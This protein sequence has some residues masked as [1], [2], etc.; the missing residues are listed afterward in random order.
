MK[1]A[2]Y[3]ASHSIDEWRRAYIDYRQLK[4]QIGRAEEELFEI[5]EGNQPSGGIGL[6]PRKKSKDRV[7]KRPSSG[8]EETEAVRDLERGRDGDAEEADADHEGAKQSEAR[9]LG[10]DTRRPPT[11]PEHEVGSPF[12][13]HSSPLASPGVSHVSESS[14]ELSDETHR[15]DTRLVPTRS[16]ASDQTPRPSMRRSSYTDFFKA[17]DRFKPT[18]QQTL[19]R[20]R[21]GFSPQMDL[22]ELIKRLPHQCRRF[23]TILDRELDKVTGFYADRE[24]EMVKRFE[25]LSAQWQELANHKK[26]YQEF[27]SR[28]LHAPHVLTSILP[29][30]APALPGTSLIRRTLAQRSPDQGLPSGNGLSPTEN[31]AEPSPNGNGEAGD[32]RGAKSPGKRKVFLHGRPEDY[33][34]ARS[35]LKLATFEYYRSLGMLKSYRV[36]NRTGFAKALKKYEKATG[37]ACASQY[38]KKVDAAPFVSSPKLDELI[39]QTEDAFATVFEHGDRKRAL[40]RLRFFGEKKHHHFAAWRAGMLM[41]A[42]LP[43]MIEG[44]VKSWQAD[45]RRS[46]PYWAGLLQLF[47][48][49]FLPVFF[50][51]AF[52]LN[53]AAWS[54]GRINYV[55]IFELDVRTKLDYHQFL[56]I[57]ATLYFILSLFF[58]AAFNNFW[59]DHIAPSAYPLAWLVVALVLLLNPFPVFYPSARW[60]MLRSMCRVV[61]SGLVDVRFRDFFLGDELNSIYYSVYNL[62]FLYCAYNKGWPSDTE[63]VCSTNKTWTTAVL[64]SLPPF[65]R[66]GQS[67]RRY[68][69]SDGLVLHLLNMGK[70]SASIMYFWFYFNWRIPEA[71]TGVSETWRLALFIVFA[72]INSI[73]VATWDILMDWS[74]GHRNAKHPWLRQELGFFKDRWQIY[75][76]IAV[77]NVV[78]RFS[79]VFYLAPHPSPAVQSYTVALVEAARRIMWNTFRVEAEH[80][81][82]R[83]GYRVTR[84]VA[85]PYVTASSPEANGHNLADDDDD[86]DGVPFKTT[87]QR[88]FARAHQLHAAL[89][90]NFAPIGDLVLPASWA[91]FFT[92]RRRRE[93][94]V[95]GGRKED[96][97]EGVDA[98]EPRG[99]GGGDQTMQ[100]RRR[101]QV[102][103]KRR[104]KRARTMEGESSSGTQESASEEEEEEDRDEDARPGGTRWANG[105]G[106]LNHDDEEEEERDPGA[107][108]ETEATK[109]DGSD[110]RPTSTERTAHKTSDDD[111]D[112]DEEL[113]RGMAEV[114]G[115][116]AFAARNA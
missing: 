31:G 22:A 72:S 55:L 38:T 70:Y 35:R 116:T 47:G 63:S 68:L 25:E 111:E 14:R 89:V 101:G 102:Q 39:R 58:W 44:L 114:E 86:A 29:H 2:R 69:D 108:E 16:N 80:I 82:N 104:L 100:R 41:G 48:A 112:E 24:G 115:M 78:L 10:G 21:P 113:R 36:L 50:S 40:E 51:L 32:G 19:K 75:Y 20:W 76:A 15:T 98:E 1:Y 84:D 87:R 88:V 13:P 73:Y 96:E 83:D 64:A 34:K 9:P 65:F 6:P 79:W 110:S 106:D 11:P 52:F 37:I 18:A 43:L 8:R 60:W 67:L 12:S 81:G 94:M 105:A 59:P 27:R 30:R 45:T 33:A 42:G 56:E 85:L 46:I 17:G 66:L 62:G 97:A 57:P 28:E 61:T 109:V 93:E 74:L 91:R 4:K 92:R 49:C 99:T 5:D 103:K 7:P 26:E 71:T 54:I 23:F 90:D 3:L 77:L 95:E 53:L 107:E